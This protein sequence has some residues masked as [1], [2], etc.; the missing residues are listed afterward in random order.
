MAFGQGD[1]IQI[2]FFG[3]SFYGCGFIYAICPLINVT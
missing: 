3:P 1:M 2:I